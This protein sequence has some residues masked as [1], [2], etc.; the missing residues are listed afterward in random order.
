MIP[1]NRQLVRDL[2]R[3]RDSAFI[4]WSYG[5]IDACEQLLGNIRELVAAPSMATPGR[6]R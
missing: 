4:L 2:R 1:Q 6:E 3:L 5:R